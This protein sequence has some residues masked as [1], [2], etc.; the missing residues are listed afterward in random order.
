MQIGIVFIQIRLEFFWDVTPHG[1]KMK[2][3]Y[4]T[5]SGNLLVSVAISTAISKQLLA[6]KTILE[7]THI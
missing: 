2:Y 3:L 7:I 1:A 4:G 5:L 6:R